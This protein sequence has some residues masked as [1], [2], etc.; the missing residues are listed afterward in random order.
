MR[1]LVT[2]ALGA[3]LSA[4]VLGST[5]F[6][7]IADAVRDHERVLARSDRGGYSGSTPRP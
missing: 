2:T 7:E 3:G 4:A 1:L 5:M 6:A